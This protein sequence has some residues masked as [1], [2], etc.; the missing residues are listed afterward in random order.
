MDR[1]PLSSENN[2][3]DMNHDRDPEK[4]PRI[5]GLRRNLAADKQGVRF[6]SNQSQL[7]SLK[8]LRKCKRLANSNHQ[9][10]KQETSHKRPPFPSQ[11]SA[12]NAEIED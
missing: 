11:W 5:V 9:P 4:V 6:N 1:G 8:K 2:A 3:V 12:E 10:V 7:S